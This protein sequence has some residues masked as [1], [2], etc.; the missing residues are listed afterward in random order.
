[1]LGK[2][3]LM[4][5]YIH[6]ENNPEKPA[7]IMAGSEEVITYK[8]LNERSNQIANLL[9]ARGLKQGDGIA[10]YMENNAQ[11]FEICWAAQRAGLYFTCFHT[12]SR[13]RKLTILCATAKRGR[14][15][16][17]ISL[18]MLRQNLYRYCPPLMP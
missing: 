11:Y 13:H 10:I 3:F 14:F 2:S 4:H 17:P 16:P 9:R 12:G 15:S 8:Q 1:M 6:A 7:Y 18:K 5:P